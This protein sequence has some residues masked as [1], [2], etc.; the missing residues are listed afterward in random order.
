MTYEIRD[1]SINDLHQLYEIEKVSF[2][3]PWKEK[4]MVYE[5]TENPVAHYLVYEDE[6]GNIVGF[7][8]YWITFDS[9]TIAQ[10]AVLPQCRRRGIA[11]E[12]LEETIKDLYA[13][14]VMTVTLEVRTHNQPAINLYHKCGFADVVIKPHYYENGDDALYMLRKVEQ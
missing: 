9:S 11:K 13:K 2:A 3:H 6:L 7:I 14:N 8:D 10:I 1:G 4:D 12:L 5:L